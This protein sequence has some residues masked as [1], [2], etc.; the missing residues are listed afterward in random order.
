MSKRDFDCRSNLPNQ[1]ENYLD[2]HT[3]PLCTCMI[4]Y[5]QANILSNIKYGG[6][7]QSPW[8]FYLT[9]FSINTLYSHQRN[10]ISLIDTSFFMPFVIH[11][12]SFVRPHMAQKVV[13][14]LCVRFVICFKLTSSSNTAIWFLATSLY[15]ILSQ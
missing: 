13:R 6:N 2:L 5:H 15:R 10:C 9:L 11:L 8:H 14:E 7:L 1:A 12:N 3:Q 4:L